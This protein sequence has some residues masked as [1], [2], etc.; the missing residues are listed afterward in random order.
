MSS[1]G[2]KLAM[3]A[4]AALRPRS[5]ACSAGFQPQA[6][7]VTVI[8]A[9]PIHMLALAILEPSNSIARTDT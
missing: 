8:A 9:T 1:L 4:I 2:S 5:P 6:T 3:L 7:T